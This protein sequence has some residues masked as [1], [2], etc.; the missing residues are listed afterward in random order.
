[1]LSKT[2]DILSVS[3]CFI[4]VYMIRRIALILLSRSE[5]NHYELFLKEKGETRVKNPDTG[6][7]VKIVSL[8]GPKGKELLDRMFQEWLKSH[9][10]DESDEDVGSSHF[11][12]YDNEEQRHKLYEG[13]NVKIKLGDMNHLRNLYGK[14]AK[15]EHLYDMVGL[16]HLIN[17]DLTL[18]DMIK[19]E[20]RIQP[21]FVAI[22]VSHPHVVSMDR[23]FYKDYIYNDCLSLSDNAPQGLGTKLL[24]Q[25]V[26][27]AA[28]R[29]L[30]HL[31]C[32]A[33]RSDPDERDIDDSWVG[34]KVWPKLGYDGEIPYEVRGILPPEFESQIPKSKPKVSDILKL[35]GGSKWWDENGGSF[36]AEFDLSKGSHSRQV[37][38]AYV[39]AK[40]KREG[41][42]PKK[43]MHS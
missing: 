24:V 25:Q 13:L 7:D 18:K 12:D 27:H 9:S 17:T 39:N 41:K 22:S 11:V 30:H 16:H 2:T 5:T 32:D 43:W 21:T 31:K 4:E 26:Q 29:G 42:S 6:R 38:E 35:E 23:H 10:Q 20:L 3:G 40:S 33:H 8:K 28:L 19:V 34:Y 14:D 36:E 37:L 1:M 15:L